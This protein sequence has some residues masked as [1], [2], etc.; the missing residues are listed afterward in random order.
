MC[1]DEN[2]DLTNEFLREPV[3]VLITSSYWST[4]ATAAAAAAGKLISDVRGAAD[5]YISYFYAVFPKMIS[6]QTTK[7]WIIVYGDLYF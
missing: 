5:D 2:N 3:S 7:N 1:D 6:Y 4:A